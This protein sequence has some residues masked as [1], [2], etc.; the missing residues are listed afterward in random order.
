MTIKRAKREMFYH[1]KKEGLRD[2]FFMS[3]ILITMC[4]E[5]KSQCS[6]KDFPM[7]G[8]KRNSGFTNMV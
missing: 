3:Q 6:T 5:S 7:N 1:K 8:C 4:R 2:Y